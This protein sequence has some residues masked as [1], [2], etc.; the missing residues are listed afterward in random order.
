MS[1]SQLGNGLTSTDPW[2]REVA[3]EEPTVQTGPAIENQ[4]A[5]ALRIP[6][7][8]FQRVTGLRVLA[9]SNGV[10]DL[11]DPTDKLFQDVGGVLQEGP[12]WAEGVALY[13]DA[14]RASLPT[15][16]PDSK[17]NK[18]TSELRSA[19]ETEFRAGTKVARSNHL[20]AFRAN[21]DEGS[22]NPNHPGYVSAV[23]AY[24]NAFTAL[25]KHIEP[26]N[27]TIAELVRSFATQAGQ[28]PTPRKQSMMLEDFK[29][30]ALEA[31]KQVR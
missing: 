6:E 2:T 20:S 26:Y 29:Y 21:F 13:V 14:L 16:V 17:A 8:E 4:L 27:P 5:T 10:K 28:A 12:G 7:D 30:K 1:I 11:F 18:A 9:G 23:K 24:S 19:W 15:S 22:K 31:L 3:R 25:A